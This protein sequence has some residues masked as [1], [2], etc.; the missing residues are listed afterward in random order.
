MSMKNRS[1]RRPFRT[2]GIVALG[3]LAAPGLAPAQTTPAMPPSSES[4]LIIQKMESGFTLAPEFKYT[5]V[6]DEFG[7]LAGIRGGWLTDDRLFIGGAGYWLTNGS[8]GRK[9]AYGGLVVE[10][11]LARTRR[12]GLSFG[13]LV[14]GGSS[15]LGVEVIGYP[16]GRL[17]GRHWRARDPGEPQTFLVAVSEG[18]FVAEPQARASLLF[19]RWLR[20]GMGVSYRLLGGAGE[21]DSRLR[22]FSG[23]VSIELGSF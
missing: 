10:W 2:A 18:Y 15:T 22:G 23:T 16:P 14:G 3:V 6:D 11:A 20:L 9:M 19:T 1:P 17:P 21:F 8:S 5:E 13:A 12:V 4:G 7:G